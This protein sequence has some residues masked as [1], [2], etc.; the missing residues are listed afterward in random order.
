MK[1]VFSFKNQHCSYVLKAVKYDLDWHYELTY[2]TRPGRIYET[3]PCG[4]Y[5]TP[6][7]ALSHGF[8]ALRNIFAP[9]PTDSYQLAQSK[10]S[11]I[12]HIDT[13]AREISGMIQ[14]EL[15]F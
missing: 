5:A 7:I 1:N 12:E 9:K 11:V 14:T 15:P 8:A 2:S 3:P 4:I 10:E 6:K 13:H